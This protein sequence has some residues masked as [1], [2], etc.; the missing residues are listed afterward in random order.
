MQQCV[1]DVVLKACFILISVEVFIEIGLGFLDGCLVLF[2]GS[3]GVRV[4]IL[5]IL[6]TQI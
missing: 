5:T 6:V 2:P 4:S 1:V 3:G